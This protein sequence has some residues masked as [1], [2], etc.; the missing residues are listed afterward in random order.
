[1]TKT[2]FTS[3]PSSPMGCTSWRDL[4]QKEAL[5][6]VLVLNLLYVPFHRGDVENGVRLDVD[7]VFEVV[8]RQLVVALTATPREWPAFS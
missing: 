3:A 7:D 5:L 4:G 1:M 2:T 8:L 6:D